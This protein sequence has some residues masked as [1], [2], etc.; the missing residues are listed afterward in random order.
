V[1]GSRQIEQNYCVRALLERAHRKE[2]PL[3]SISEVGYFEP[4]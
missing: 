2:L 3:P 1:R 4:R